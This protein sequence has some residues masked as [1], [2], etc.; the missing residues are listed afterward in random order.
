MISLYLGGTP[1][2]WQVGANQGHIDRFEF[3]LG[4]ADDPLSV[5][6]HDQVQ[7]IVGM[8]MDR[9]FEADIITVQQ[10]E[11]VLVCQWRYF[12]L[13]IEHDIKTQ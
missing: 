3:R 4:I 9:I 12:L 10:Y 11:E 6:F 13:V 8:E 7:L 2:M 1:G 5:C